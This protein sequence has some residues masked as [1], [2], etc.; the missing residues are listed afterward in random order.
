MASVSEWYSV[1]D[2]SNN[3]KVAYHIASVV[4]LQGVDWIDMTS[5]TSGGRKGSLW[6]HFYRLLPWVVLSGVGAY[7]DPSLCRALH[8]YKKITAGRLEAR[9]AICAEAI[10]NYSHIRDVFWALLVT[11]VNIGPVGSKVLELASSAVLLL[12]KPCS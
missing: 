3:R 12:K 10:E 1:K 5:E 4:D 8:V 11:R 6:R 2:E 7:K 9:S